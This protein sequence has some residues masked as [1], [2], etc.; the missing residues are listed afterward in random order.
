MTPSVR[1]GA[2]RIQATC[3]TFFILL[4]VIRVRGRM[5]SKRSS[6]NIGLGRDAAAEREIH[7]MLHK[8]KGKISTSIWVSRL[9]SALEVDDS[10][11]SG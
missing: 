2:S 4:Y 8:V 5:H 7:L 6:M 9:S 10:L 11:P 1:A 3:S